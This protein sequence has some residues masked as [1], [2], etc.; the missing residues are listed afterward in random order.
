MDPSWAEEDEFPNAT[1]SPRHWLTE[2]PLSP[3]PGSVNETMEI[4]SA[5]TSEKA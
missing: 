2:F 5:R 1:P 4:R 3:W